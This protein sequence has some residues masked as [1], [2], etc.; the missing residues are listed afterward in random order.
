MSTFKLSDFASIKW[1]KSITADSPVAT[2]SSIQCA[3]TEVNRAPW[4]IVTSQDNNPILACVA[5]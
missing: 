3:L 4:N 1:S 2:T 5:L